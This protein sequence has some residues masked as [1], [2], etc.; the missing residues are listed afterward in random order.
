M[1]FLKEHL[2]KK[3]YDWAVMHHHCKENNEPNRRT[4]NPLNGYQV[5]FIINHFGKSIGKLTITDGCQLEELISTQLP[6]ELKSELSVFNWLRGI[7]L[8]YSN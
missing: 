3:N 7:Y 5:L 4:F 6:L 8:Y 2:R 1:I